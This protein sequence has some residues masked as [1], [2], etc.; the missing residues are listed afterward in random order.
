LGPEGALVVLASTL[1]DDMLDEM[2]DSTDEELMPEELVSI[3]DGLD[4]DD[5]ELKEVMVALT[6]AEVEDV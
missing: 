1:E 2:L 3:A 5:E 6:L 4:S